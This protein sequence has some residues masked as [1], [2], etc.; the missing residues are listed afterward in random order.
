MKN[1]QDYS[2]ELYKNKNL[3]RKLSSLYVD[4]A[5]RY[6]YLAEEKK[7]LR[8][9]KA[10]FFDSNKYEDGKP[11]AVVK[12]EMKWLLTPDGERYDSIKIDMD[13]VKELM[14]AIKSISITTHHEI[15]NEL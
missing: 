13:A 11:I 15:K 10:R 5:A 2:T 8:I 6:S 12:L 3:P 7:G 9:L 4:L 1:L 14:G